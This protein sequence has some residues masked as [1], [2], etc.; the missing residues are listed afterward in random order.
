VNYY[1]Q[2]LTC[3]YRR[4]FWVKDM[5]EHHFLILSLSYLRKILLTITGSQYY[6][7]I[8]H[9]LR[10]CHIDAQTD[11]YQHNFE[12]GQFF[13]HFGKFF[14]LNLIIS[15]FKTHFLK[16]QISAGNL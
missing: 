13:E 4:F 9:F 1:Q 6:C 2:V 7:N 12:I 14:D 8:P 15:V 16:Y 3:K 10:T 5:Y 11:K